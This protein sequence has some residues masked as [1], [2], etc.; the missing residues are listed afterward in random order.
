MKK[1]ISFV[2]AM[3]MM[4]GLFGCTKPT[5]SQNSENESSS[6]QS[7]KGGW[8]FPSRS[9]NQ[10]EEEKMDNYASDTSAKSYI[11]GMNLG[12]VV[13]DRVKEYED[14]WIN[15]I[16]DTHDAIFDIYRDAEKCER[17]D[18]QGLLL[19]WFAEYVGKMLVSCVTA[20]RV[21]G[22][23][24]TRET[25]QDLINNIKSI[26]KDDGYVGPYPESYTRPCAV[27]K[28]GHYFI[29]I[30]LC[31][32]YDLTGDEDALQ[33]AV[34]AADFIYNS[35]LLNGEYHSFET[36]AMN[37]S[38]AHGY[39][40]LYERTHDLKYYEAAK[41]CVK[42]AWKIDGNWYENALAGKDYYET[43]SKRWECLHAIMALGEL[44]RITGDEDYFN[45]MDQIWWSLLKTDVH[46]TGGWS[47][48]E[49]V[50][51][52]PYNNGTIETCCTVAWMAFSS[53]YLK[54]TK[55]PYVADELERS[56]LNGML[57]SIIDGT[58]VTYG[59][60]MSGYARGRSNATTDPTK[61]V[62]ECPDFTCCTCNGGRGVNMIAN[63]GVIGDESAIYLNYFGPSSI[64]T[65]TPSGKRIAITQNTN[66]PI[67]GKIDITLSLDEAESFDF[68]VRIPT[69]AGEN[70]A[71]KVNGENVSVKAGE[72][73]K[74]SR[75][76]KNGDSLEL[77]IDMTV[78][79]LVGDKDCVNLTSVYYGPI[80]MTL[81]ESLYSG[82]AYDTVFTADA[83]KNVKYGGVKKGTGDF[84]IYFDVYDTNGNQVRLT[85]FASA[86]RTAKF[87]TWLHVQ[88]NMLVLTT[89][90]GK[91]PTWLNTQA[92]GRELLKD[93][94]DTAESRDL[95][96]YTAKT[97][98]A[99]E[100]SLAEAKSV[101]TN[102][103]I[104]EEGVSEAIK[105]LHSALFALVKDY[106]SYMCASEPMNA[107]IVLSKFKTIGNTV[108]QA[109]NGIKIV[110]SGQYWSYGAFPAA[111]Y[112]EKVGLNGLTVEF[113]MDGYG[114]TQNGDPN[115]AL[116]ITE[117]AGVSAWGVTSTSG[118]GYMIILPVSKVSDTSVKIRGMKVY[119]CAQD[120][121]YAAKPSPNTKVGNKVQ[122]KLVQDE[123]L[124]YKIL[125]NGEVLEN[126]SKNR[127]L[128][129]TAMCELFKDGKAYVS[130]A[131]I[132][133]V[134]NYAAEV[135]LTKIV[136]E[137]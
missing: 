133:G 12:G 85:D 14:N 125:V 45:A 124:G 5:S 101:Y 68:C 81:D 116:Y 44:Y 16:F 130:L 7:S 42:K 88:H 131:V 22:S 11:R 20:Y 62:H 48:N 32:W 134:D 2:L 123:T 64:E 97:A 33:M 9:D 103:A 57:G 52:N 61:V 128:D 104:S 135:T 115:V 82:D 39:A 30:G 90:K 8:S 96:I 83:F 105:K 49:I 26:Q 111:T 113:N 43:K 110:G 70:T 65:Q 13:G 54:I 21:S 53:D 50:T 100:E 25:V 38:I 55:N 99:V 47:T 34:R 73:A 126:A 114:G 29:I 59:T 80:L 121:Y 10:K 91:T 24:E 95:S 74:I 63:W 136:V 3:V 93:L 58:Y 129:L 37:V 132:M 69:W 60:N 108:S 40:V 66:Y 112:D 67:R 89:E 118:N 98:S 79:F 107:E 127:P 94:I 84:W 72:Y 56:Y 35:E 1:I 109:E 27:D 76:W 19:G 6:N 41:Y 92:Q 78:H 23:E 117:N 87:Q 31:D 4:I 51:G 18:K 15:S 75:E 102:A 119:E 122:I 120:I 28:W 71:L 46:N 137:P 36:G 17:Y 106:S 77:D 86:G